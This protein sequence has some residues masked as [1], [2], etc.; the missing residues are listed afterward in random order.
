MSNESD[1]IRAALQLS[2]EL[3][4]FM[5]RLAGRGPMVQ[6]GALADLVSMFITGHIV[7][8]DRQATYRAREVELELFFRAV[9]ALVAPSAEKM[10]T[11]VTQHEEEFREVDD[12]YADRAEWK[13]HRK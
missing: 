10:A 11:I 12:D 7:P 4:P 6:G 3:Q 2:E 1:I 9:R 8:G 13:A 5:D